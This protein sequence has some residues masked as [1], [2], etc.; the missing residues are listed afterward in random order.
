[1]ATFALPTLDSTTQDGWGPNGT[2]NNFKVWLLM[3]KNK[4]SKNCLK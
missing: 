2:P 3:L 4:I 1:M